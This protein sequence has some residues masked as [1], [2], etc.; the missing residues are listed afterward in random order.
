MSF[1]PPKVN[2]NDSLNSLEYGTS[3]NRLIQLKKASDGTPQSL[4]AWDTFRCEFKDKYAYLSGATTN[5]PQPVVTVVDAAN[6]II[7]LA[8]STWPS[9]CILSGVYDIEANLTGASPTRI[10]KFAYGNWSVNRRASN[11]YDTP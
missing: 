6:G 11:S 7:Q 9:T 4:A 8:F 2:L 3:F 5:C 1:V 10:E